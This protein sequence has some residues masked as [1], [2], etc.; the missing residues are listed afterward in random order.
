MGKCLK[1][2]EL[3]VRNINIKSDSDEVSDVNEEHVSKTE[4]Q[5]LLNSGKGHG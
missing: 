2:F 1:S 3:H 5:S 4:R